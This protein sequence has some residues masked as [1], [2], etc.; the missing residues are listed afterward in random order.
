VEG[1]YIFLGALLAF[2][3]GTAR[4]IWSDGR[5]KQ[6]LLAGLRAEIEELPAHIERQVRSMNEIALLISGG[7]LPAVASAPLRFHVW[8]G[9]MDEIVGLLDKE[10]STNVRGAFGRVYM[11]EAA[12][13]D[14]VERL[15]LLWTADA[16]K[17]AWERDI[18]L[19]AADF[20]RGGDQVAEYLAESSGRWDRYILPWHRR[21]LRS[22]RRR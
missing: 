7:Q 22:F 1:L 15:H 2:S 9:R 17:A 3:F 21:A 18:Y 8:E 13:A 20:K 5:K 14:K 10:D 19:T 12:I 16:D 4:E 6:Q 11:H